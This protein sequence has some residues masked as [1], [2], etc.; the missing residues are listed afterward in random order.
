MLSGPLLV[1]K[2]KSKPINGIKHR[3]RWALTVFE[4]KDYKN[5]LKSTFDQKRREDAKF[6]LSYFSQL[7][8][9]SDSYLRQILADRRKLNIE[10]AALLSKKLGH[11]Q[12]E[13]SYFL[14]LVL[15]EDANTEPLRDYFA[16]I[17]ENLN[18]YRS[19]NFDLVDEINVVFKN[20]QTWILY[21]LVGT[22]DFKAD[23]E[24]INSNLK[25]KLFT[26][27]SIKEGLDHLLRHNAIQKDHSGHYKSKN[28]VFKDSQEVRRVYEGAFL[29][30][31]KYLKSTSVKDRDYFD[32][33]C[34]IVTE[35]EYLQIQ[36]VLERT[37][38]EIT[39]SVQKRKS[40]DHVAFYLSGLFLE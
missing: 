23:P 26:M 12:L 20:P 7:I 32:A 10:K 1:E 18:Q 34:M 19:L 29:H 37:K 6:S 21:T 28:I 16:S 35:K 38:K 36:S 30:A 17:L 8:G 5:Y 33:F 25:S 9:T 24:W 22:R 11:S 31:M 40:G 4:A 14:T 3:Q 13:T 39:E 15:K 2:T 27:S